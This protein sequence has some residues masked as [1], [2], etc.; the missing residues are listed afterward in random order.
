M[1]KG[2]T[3]REMIQGGVAA[4]LSTLLPSGR[5]LAQTAPLIV[6]AIPSSGERVPAVGI[7]TARRY[8]VGPDAPERAEITAV[9]KLFVELGGMVIDTAPSYGQA[10]IVV[11]DTTA[12]LGNRARLFLATKVGATGRAAAEAQ[13]AQSFRRLRTDTIDLIAVHNLTDTRNQLAY[14]RELKQAK[15]IRYVGVTTSSDQQYAALEDIM[16]TEALD[17]IQVDYAIDNRGVADRLLPLA[18]DRGVGVMINLPFGRG[19][20]FQAVQGRE[21]PPWAAE[22]DCKTWAQFFL[23][24]IVAHPAVTCVVPG[25]AQVKYVADNLAGAQGRLPT[26]ALLRRMEEYVRKA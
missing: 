4:A 20:V 23:K 1:P 16:K 24:Y 2:L 6:R 8:D 26:P 5:L 13:V 14:L 10:E 3:R 7:G 21:L 19:R 9:V 12:A 25:T 15:R 18:A 22:F 17:V 11:G